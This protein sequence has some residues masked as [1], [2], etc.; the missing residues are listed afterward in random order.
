MSN[1]Q[2]RLKIIKSIF[3]Y[4]LGVRKF[5][6][7]LCLCSVSNMFITLS[8]PLFYKTLIDDVII[9]GNISSL[10]IVVAGYTSI[11]VAGLFV[12]FLKTY[13]SNKLINESLL[14][15]RSSIFN[16][17]L[18]MSFEKYNSY[19]VGDLRLRLDDDSDKLS[20]FADVQTSR[21]I[22][23][24]VTITIT[25]L[26]LFIISWQLALFSMIIV[27]I[28]FYLGHI[29]SKAEG[30]LLEQRRIYTAS[31]DSWLYGSLTGWKEVKALN[32]Q[33]HQFRIF[34]SN[35]HKVALNN[36][37]WIMFW[38]LRVLVIPMIKDEFLMKF[39]LYFIGGIL[40]MKGHFTVGVLLV[41]MRYYTI[42]YNNINEVNNSDI[43]LRENKPSYN[44]IL[45]VINLSTSK[46]YNGI[47]HLTGNIS[48]NNVSFA[49]DN[50]LS[51]VLTDVAFNIRKGE[52]IAIVGKSGSGK[53][54]ILKLLLGMIQ[55]ETGA[56]L[57]DGIDINK[58][59]PSVLH[60]NIGV[61]MQDSILFN[62]SI[63]DNLKFIKPDCTDE[64]IA[65]ACEKSGILDFIQALPQKYHTI[66]GEK[67]VKLSGGQRQR[68]AIARIF[69]C[70]P[71][72]VVFD[73][74]TSALDKYSEG[75]IHN[76][77]TQLKNDTS[78]IIVAHRLS[79]VL[80]CDKIVVLKD[81][82]ITGIGT[83]AQLLE[84]N[85]S[86]NELFGE[87]YLSA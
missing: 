11:Y 32:L 25:T 4:T 71:N 63:K 70:E 18:E 13:S 60:K 75:I 81:G 48:V 39:S 42:F 12:D 41:F 78:I 34:V 72:I 23:S 20:I 82:K 10:I 54:T 79:S 27:P 45:D 61:V 86:Y 15:I 17:Y 68:L 28:T 65:I 31:N 62:M 8:I 52:K 43:Q 50:Q 2:Y 3:P 40:V 22:I 56:L 64:D 26:T 19:T 55:C 59:C 21:W 33:K 6:L 7:L 9:S 84:N 36:S 73:E 69:L 35:I 1:I 47:K 49:Y 74:A 76:S 67:G 24:L 80:L 5:F 51:N 38:T 57:F 29:V 44:R 66:I 58:I 46:T 30:K 37:K 77:I 85:S 83:P 14:K 87:Q 53:T 16:N